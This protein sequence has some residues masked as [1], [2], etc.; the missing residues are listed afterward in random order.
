MAA[1]FITFE[2]GEGAGKSTQTRGLADRLARRAVRS[3]VTRE[4][5]GSAFAE[6]IRDLLLSRDSAAHDAL[7][8][9]LLFYAARGDH[10]AKVIRPALRRGDWVICDRFSDSTRV[11]QGV[12]GGVDEQT[13]AALE[14]MVVADTRPD[15]TIILDLPA[16][17]G[18]ARAA[19]RREESRANGPDRFESRDLVFH[20]RLRDGFLA[21]AKDEPQR[22][23]VIDA[24]AGIEEI[25]DKIWQLVKTRLLDGVASAGQT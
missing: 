11:Y 17:E 25:A 22:C 7:A 15:L 24:R 5:G 14:K 16:C 10:L 12:A 3:V 6:Q 8:E 13:I 4:P 9:T 18:M 20:D 23:V 2:G 21:L 1:K 19:A